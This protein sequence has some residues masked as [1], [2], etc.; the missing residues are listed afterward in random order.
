MET[1]GL[2]ETIKEKY[3]NLLTITLAEKKLISKGYWE[4]SHTSD[5]VGFLKEI[6]EKYPFMVKQNETGEDFLDT[7]Y[8]WELS[9]CNLKSMYFGKYNNSEKKENIK[10]HIQNKKDYNTTARTSY[11]VSFEYRAEA[12]KAWY[13]EE[14]KNCGN[15]HYYLA[16]DHN[17][18]LF[19]E[20]D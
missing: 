6:K 4:K 1:S 12:K 16:L 15:G 3:K 17:T 7:D 2:W 9:E 20:N 13:S 11:D 18:A 5:Y 10:R 14:Y 19:C 8:I